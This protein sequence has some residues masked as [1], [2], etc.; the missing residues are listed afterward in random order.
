[1]YKRD[2]RLAELLKEHDI[3]CTDVS[4]PWFTLIKLGIKTVEGRLNKTDFYKIKI[5]DTIIFT[6]C[7]FEFERKIYVKIINIKDYENFDL[8]LQNEKLENCLPGLD[9][10]EEGIKIL[11]NYYTSFDEY[12][13]KVRA[14]QFEK[15]DI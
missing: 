4:E 7:D 11:Y 6:N 3:Y 13:Y 9:T 2:K 12:K 14:I 8:Y 15:Y 1:M 10:I 5:G